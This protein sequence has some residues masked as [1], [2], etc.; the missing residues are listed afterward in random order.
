MDIKTLKERLLT[1]DR[2]AQDIFKEIGYE[3]KFE[4][5]NLEF[6]KE[7]LD[8]YMMY[9]EF[10]S[11]CSHL[12]YIH[13]VLD[14][15]QKPVT[16]AG[17]TASIWACTMDGR[18]ETQRNFSAAILPS[19]TVICIITA[20]TI[21]PLPTCPMLRSKTVH[22]TMRAALIRSM[23]LTLNQIRATPAAT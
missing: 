20:E 10:S 5:T 3:K 15:L 6:D 23:A 21:S 9:R 17:E 12:D 11:I 8:D 2:E 7:N 1:L 4:I 22:L 18:T 13:V 19:P 14:Y 16:N